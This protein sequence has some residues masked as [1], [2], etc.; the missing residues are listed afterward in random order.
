MININDPEVRKL[1]GLGDITT[2]RDQG[3]NLVDNN[4]NLTGAQKIANL[5]AMSAVD[6]SVPFI[7]GVGEVAYPNQPFVDLTKPNWTQFSER[8]DEPPDNYSKF[9]HGDPRGEGLPTTL[10][11]EIGQY[12][13]E[14]RAVTE[15]NKIR[16]RMIA[17]G[18]E[19]EFEQYLKE[20]GGGW[21]FSMERA[22][23][24]VFDM[25]SAGN[26]AVVGGL[27]EYWKSGNLSWALEQA[28]DEFEEAMPFLVAEGETHQMSFDDFFVKNDISFAG[29]S[30]AGFLLDVIVDPINFLPAGVL[31]KAGAK[32]GKAT[33]A[34]GNLPGLRL[35]KKITGPLGEG[36]NK[37]FRPHV[38]IERIGA[39]FVRTDME[40]AKAEIGRG[41]NDVQKTW[42]ALESSLTPTEKQLM[43]AYLDKPEELRSQLNRLVDKGLVP[44]Q[45]MADFS[46][47][48]SFIRTQLA[49]YFGKENQRNLVDVSIFE[50][51]YVPLYPAT[52]K[53]S[54]RASA[55]MLNRR[56]MDITAP[57]ETAPFM[58]QRQGKTQAE[59][60]NSMLNEGEGTLDLDI[61]SQV[62][63]R[64][65]DHVRW[66]VSRKFHQGL[67]NNHTPLANGEAF[68]I[69]VNPEMYADKSTWE[70]FKKT[71]QQK[72]P[73]R[74]VFE[75][76]KRVKVAETP[77]LKKNGEPSL[78]KNGVPRTKGGYFEDQVVEAALLP[79]VVVQH[80]KRG[81]ASFNS[82]S[83]LEW[84]LDKV[85]DMT[86]IWRGWATLSPGYHARNSIGIQIIN[87]MRGVGAKEFEFKAGPINAGTWRLPTGIGLMTRNL[88]ALKMQTLMEGAGE[89]PWAA[90]KKANDTAKKLGLKSFMEIK[91]PQIK[92]DGKMVDTTWDELIRLAQEN[93]VTQVISHAGPMGENVIDDLWRK[94]GGPVMSVSDVDELDIDESVKIAMKRQSESGA[95]QNFGDK[96]N[97][98]IFAPGTDNAFLRWNRQFA[99]VP[100]NN[101]RL[102]MFI[103]RL[104]KGDTAA[105]A[106]EQTKIWHF[107]YRRLSD[108]EQKLFSTMSPFYAWSRFS[109]PRMMMAFIEDPARMSKIPKAYEMVQN[110]TRE[111][112]YEGNLP[113]PDYYDELMSVQLPAMDDAGYPIYASVDL[114]INELNRLNQKD[115]IAGLHP[116]VKVFFEDAAGQSFFTGTPIER[117][118]GEEEEDV[119]Y[120]PK[121][122]TNLL[123]LES[124]P[125]VGR[126]TRQVIG[127]INPFIERTLF[128]P[129][130]LAAREQTGY[131]FTRELGPNIRPLDVRRT[132]RGRN[133]EMLKLARDFERQFK[134]EQAN[135]SDSD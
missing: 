30:V 55:Q 37:V 17:E 117:F 40:K 93:D 66:T 19:D 135:L 1:F 80:M 92:V 58:Y 33:Q 82:N 68:S 51:D 98:S 130:Q 61:I 22:L 95:G 114:P 74:E 53:G 20:R 134:Q 21:D 43:A 28:S 4:P 78:D 35:H 63:R 27:D 8:F 34:V 12:A 88:Q 101:G 123:G 23:D 24:T 94:D 105:E 10:D 100:E 125:K 119:R 2:T 32:A 52:M 29:Q 25:L 38:A 83:D 39:G 118:P 85:N 129:Q 69:K 86:S 59:Y 44:E 127:A 49:D 121:S 7:P 56:M 36:F 42:E 9:S 11:L 104:A 71:Y 106:A 132:M 3:R 5:G 122:F 90:G 73:D 13:A 77:I 79:K 124:A 99:T 76:T 96:F 26:Y 15:T 60:I 57:N 62:K 46:E 41:V 102:A 45:N 6:L 72:H 67:I 91:A 107:D 108:I 48:V 115:F 97:R 31:V 110:I 64:G 120:L 89:L 14:K 113:T 16:T 109:L 81:Q 111:L 50:H 65:Y 18:R 70:N 126:K 131:A 54:K 112:G 47:N 75:L 87:W 128:R 133:F 116:A 103:D 84:F